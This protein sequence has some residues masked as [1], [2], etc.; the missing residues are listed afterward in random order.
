MLN[1]PPY[2]KPD[3]GIVFVTR[4]YPGLK[5]NGAIFSHPNPWAWGAA[6]ALGDGESAMAFYDALCPYNQN[7]KIEI[8]QAEPYVYCQFVVGKAH[9]AF[10]RARHP[11]MTGSAG[12][13]YFAATEYILGIRPDYDRLIV[14]PV[15]PRDWKAFSLRRVWRGATYDIQVSNPNAVSRGVKSIRV[16]GVPVEAIPPLPAGG[17]CR[18]EVELG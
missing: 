1:A 15:I 3:D 18:V 17:S 11:F 6:S 13:S 16:D 12:W 4:V 7:D 2:T 5:E 10:G 14:D 9:T 8:R